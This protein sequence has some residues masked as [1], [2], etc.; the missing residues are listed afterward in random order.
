MCFATRYS[1]RVLCSTRAK[2]TAVIGLEGPEIAAVQLLVC[3]YLYL[4]DDVHITFFNI[5]LAKLLESKL[6]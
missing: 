3:M 4:I 6:T 1:I 2:C 5:A